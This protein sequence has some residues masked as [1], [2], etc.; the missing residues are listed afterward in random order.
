VEIGVSI[1]DGLD[2]LSN[3]DIDDAVS[4]G[5]LDRGAVGQFDTNPSRDDLWRWTLRFGLQVGVDRPGQAGRG[6]NQAPS[7]IGSRYCSG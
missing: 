3:N 5:R 1:V 4:L 7:E 2:C 6:D